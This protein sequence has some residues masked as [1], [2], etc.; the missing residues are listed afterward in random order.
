MMSRNNQHGFVLVTTL[1]ILAAITIGVAYFSERVDRSRMQALQT[2]QLAESLVDIADTRA[3]VLFRLGTTGFSVHGLGGSAADAIRLD[4]RPYRG[5]GDDVVRL[6]DNRGLLNLNL[7][8][9]ELLLR[10]LGQFG[11][12]AENQGPMLDAL[13]DYIDTDDLRRLNGAEAREYEMLS[14]PPPA[15][16]WLVT[17]YQLQNIIGWR[18]QAGLWKDQRFLQLVTTSRVNWFNPNTAP[19]EVLASLP[20][21]SRVIAEKIVEFR[22]DI[23]FVSTAQLANLAGIPGLNEE[24]VMFFP[25]NSIRITQQSKNLPWMVQYSVT[26]TPTSNIAPWRIDYYAKNAAESLVENEKE[27]ALLPARNSQSSAPAEA[28]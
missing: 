1:W 20:G 12:P 18:N 2:Q 11:V 24:S 7:L 9:A 16:D 14:L 3:E 10:L 19:L 17:P 15:N 27:I 6:Q 21:S 23:P 26:L 22:R 25:S 13:Q 5:T 28:L 4:D 8:D